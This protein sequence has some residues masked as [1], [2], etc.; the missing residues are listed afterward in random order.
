VSE[1]RQRSKSGER[2]ECVGVRSDV[3]G[4]VFSTMMLPR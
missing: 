3:R 4:G 2:A 1:R